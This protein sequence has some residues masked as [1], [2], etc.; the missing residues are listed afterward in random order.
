VLA[1]ERCSDGEKETSFDVGNGLRGRWQWCAWLTRFQDT[2][3]M[4]WIG[5]WPMLKWAIWEWQSRRQARDR[6][7]WW[8]AL[9]H[10]TWRGQGL[11]H[12]T[13]DGA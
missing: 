12:G 4:N 3:K 8:H 5:R 2:F 7:A 9:A 10:G 6:E 13:L 1:T 11:V